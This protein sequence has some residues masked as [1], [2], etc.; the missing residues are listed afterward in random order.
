VLEA[1]TAFTNLTAGNA[2]A[3]DRALENITTR[4]QALDNI[5]PSQA[6]DNATSTHTTAQAYA[7]EVPITQARG[8]D[9]TT[10]E[11]ATSTHT[12][13]QAYASEVPITQARGLVDTTSENASAELH[14]PENIN[15][16]NTSAQACAPANPVTR[17][18]GLNNA[19]SEEAVVQAYPSYSITQTRARNDTTSENAGAETLTPE[20]TISE[21]TSAQACV[22]AIPITQAQ[23]LHNTISEEVTAQ[24]YPSNS[25]TVARGLDHISS[26]NAIAEA[27]IPET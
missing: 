14:T 4:S 27:R 9:V 25:L 23:H 8:L 26:A 10:S 18:Q 13:A 19:T 22:A 11:N 5:A 3:E 1:H 21:N 17:A 20:N 12:T 2:I 24:A 15:S 6:F 16:Q 7:S